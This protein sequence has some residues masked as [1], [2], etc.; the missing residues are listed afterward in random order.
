MEAL[1]DSR[2]LFLVSEGDTFQGKC[3]L[4]REQDSRSGAFPEGGIFRVG[5]DVSVDLC[6]ITLDAVRGIRLLS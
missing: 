2:S 6:F 4:L 1:L 3:D 5:L